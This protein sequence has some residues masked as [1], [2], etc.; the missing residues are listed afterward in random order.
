[1]RHPKVIIN[2]WTDIGV[3]DD[4]IF[5]AIND[6]VGQMIIGR[7]GW[8]MAK[9]RLKSKWISYLATNIVRMYVSEAS[10]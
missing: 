6:C 1:M 4:V 10:G 8:Q 9:I 7:S 3:A 5:L 2:Q